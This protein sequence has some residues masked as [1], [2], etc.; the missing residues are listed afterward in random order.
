[1][2][3]DP[4]RRSVADI[5]SHWGFTHLGRFAA[6]YRERYGCVPSETLRS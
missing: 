2:V 3:A 6:A 5:A 4:A 1:Q